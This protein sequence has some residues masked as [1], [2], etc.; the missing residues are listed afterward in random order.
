[1]WRTYI[2]KNLIYPHDTMF[3]DFP[4]PEQKIDPDSLF[5]YS[6]FVKPGKHRSLLYD[7]EEDVW[8]KRDFY[9]DEREMDVPMFA[10]YENVIAEKSSVM[11]SLLK[12][13]KEDN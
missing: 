13:W 10:N 3:I 2:L 8:Y 12:D 1:M 5:M 11:N 9:I 7:P 6:G 4:T